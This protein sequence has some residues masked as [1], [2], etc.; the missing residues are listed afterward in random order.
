M[1]SISK[2]FGEHKRVLFR[3]TK[4]LSRRRFYEFLENS[5][6]A[7]SSQVAGAGKILNIGAGGGVGKLVESTAKRISALVISVDV[8]SKR[9]PDIRCDVRNL[10]FRD[11]A[12]DCVVC[13]EVLEHV[14]YPRES[15]CGI[16]RVLR[17]GGTLILTTRF[18]YPLHDRPGDYF[19][20]TKYGLNALLTDFSQVSIRE[21]LNWVETMALLVMRL[22]KEDDRWVK[23][24][25]APIYWSG[26]FI[27]IASKLIAR[28]FTT[29]Y[30]T[31]GY[32]VL[33]RK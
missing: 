20:Y 27:D 30:I 28:R 17:D 33:A 4:A 21:H 31:S 29:D 15:V 13:A 6:V 23:L 2:W 9:G 10:P 24:L 7:S 18:I 3:K 26:R 8:D 16:H 19:R 22:L 5:I 14:L 12:F 25:A 11:S 1:S 32:L